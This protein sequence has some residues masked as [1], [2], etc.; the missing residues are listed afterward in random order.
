[1]RGQLKKAGSPWDRLDG[2]VT[3][4]ACTFAALQT[5]VRLYTSPEKKPS[6]I[7]DVDESSY[8]IVYGCDPVPRAFAMLNF[9]GQM[10]ETDP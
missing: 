5:V 4:L 6:L 1:M 2:K 9:I 10:M 3:W 7:D 8:N